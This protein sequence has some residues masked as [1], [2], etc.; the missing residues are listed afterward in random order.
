MWI[1]FCECFLNHISVS[2]KSECGCLTGP[3]QPRLI[4]KGNILSTGDPYT[5]SGPFWTGIACVHIFF[6]CVYLTYTGWNV[7]A[8]I[9][10]LVRR[11]Q[12]Y[13]QWN[14]SLREKQ[15]IVCWM[16]KDARWWRY[17]LPIQRVLGAVRAWISRLFLRSCHFCV[18]DLD[19]WLVAITD[20]HTLFLRASGACIC[21]AP[22]ECHEWPEGVYSYSGG[23][24]G[25]GATCMMI[26]LGE[27]FLSESALMLSF[28]V[29]PKLA[30]LRSLSPPIITFKFNVKKMMYVV[31]PWWSSGRPCRQIYII[32]WPLDHILCWW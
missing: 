3:V 25:Q 24:N 27:F 32:G 12:E 22:R 18:F 5:S 19:R 21:T 31:L 4:Q 28:Q 20:S 29:R 7:S 9:F 1:W 15:A 23:C 30:T 2:W 13:R 11:V 16:A 6:I 8:D 17:L 10:K 14:F 26:V